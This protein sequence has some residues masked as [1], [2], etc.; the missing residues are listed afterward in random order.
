MDE[1][2][3]SNARLYASRRQLDLAESLG[4]GKDGIVL[5]AKRKARPGKVAIKVFRFAE[6]YLREKLVYEYWR[7][8][9][10]SAFI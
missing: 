6:F 3:T 2:L 4:S 7:R 1:K 8:L 9:K 5:A 10:I